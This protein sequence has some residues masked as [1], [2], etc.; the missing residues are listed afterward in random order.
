[1][2]DINVEFLINIFRYVVYMYVNIVY[3]LFFG[4]IVEGVFGGIEVVL[5][6]LLVVVLSGLYVLLGCLGNGIYE[7][8]LFK[9]LI[10]FRFLEL[11]GNEVCILRRRKIYRCIIFL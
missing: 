11:I 3:I 4:L 2:G 1:M 9:V 10:K 8:D 6:L 7:F 5:L